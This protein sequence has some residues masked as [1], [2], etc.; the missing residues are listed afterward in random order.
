[1]VKI[2]DPVIEV[3]D[4]FFNQ[5]T[6]ADDGTGYPEP[7][8]RDSLLILMREIIGLGD[9]D[10]Q[11]KTG[12]LT[13]EELG[14]PKI[15]VR[16]AIRIASYAETEGHFLVSNYFAAL[17][18]SIAGRGL[19]KNALLV[20]LPFTQRRQTENLGTPK[21]TVKKAWHGGETVVREGV[22]HE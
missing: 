9:P 18:G 7:P 2:D 16:D 22:A 5:A 10:S 14:K 19:S 3:P 13:K 11:V 1:M 21:T 17:A 8:R 20:Q 15:N 4:D 12:N 6:I